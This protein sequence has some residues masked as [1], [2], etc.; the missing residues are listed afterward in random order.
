MNEE[1]GWENVPLWVQREVDKAGGS[2]RALATASGVDAR[3]ITKLLNGEPVKRRDA[4]VRLATHSGWPTDAFDRMRRG[5]SPSPAAEIDYLKGQSETAEAKFNE[6]HKIEIEGGDL[7]EDQHA[8]LMHWAMESTRLHDRAET[9][10]RRLRGEPEP[11]PSKSPFGNDLLGAIAGDPYLE[12]PDKV[13]LART[14]YTLQQAAWEAR[15]N[16]ATVD[17]APLIAAVSDAHD[18]LTS[19]ERKEIL[20]I[21]QRARRRRQGTTPA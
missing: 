11:P 4:L 9:M 18:N 6:L 5:E 8:L 19:E 7:D 3:T 13:N 10:E 21:A 1:H 15:H 2:V 20:D 16:E 14:A 17:E 12:M